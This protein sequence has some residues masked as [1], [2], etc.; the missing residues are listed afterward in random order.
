[1][2]RAL[3]IG[4]V[5]SSVVPDVLAQNK[6]GAVVK[7]KPATK[8]NEIKS[9]LP[10]AFNSTPNVNLPVKPVDAGQ[11][12]KVRQSAARIDSLIDSKLK[13]EGL[14]P[15]PGI[16]DDRFV[17]RVYLDITG[18]IPTGREAY[19]FV[20]SQLPN[21]REVLVDFLLNS[22]GYSSHMFN[23]FADTWRI[24]DKS[25]NNTYIRPWADWVKRSL[26]QNK[27]YDLM[28]RQM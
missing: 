25:T 19:L 4:L 23:Y 7:K 14:Q 11:I 13:A 2:L 8:P 10:A 28:V 24:V 5:F 17:R 27:P 3:M 20:R 6:P 21:K 12:A 16:D 26:R 22:V 1:M 18:Q 9:K 15:N